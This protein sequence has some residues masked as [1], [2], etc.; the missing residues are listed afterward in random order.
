MHGLHNLRMYVFMNMHEMLHMQNV[1]QL[2]ENLW[3]LVLQQKQCANWGS[4]W[5]WFSKLIVK[6]VFKAHRHDHVQPLLQALHWL[7]VN[8]KIHY[9]LSTICH[10][11]SWLIPC[12]SP[13]TFSLCVHLPHSLV[14]P[15]THGHFAS[16]MLKLNLWPT[17]LLCSEAVEFSPFPHLSHSVLPCFKPALKTPLQS[18]PQPTFQTLS[19]SFCPPPHPTPP[20][21]LLLSSMLH[22]SCALQH[23]YAC[24]CVRMCGVQRIWCILF[25]QFT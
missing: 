16:S 13:L 18:I 10:N 1:T 22:F 24:M 4:W 5:N 9:T 12:I 15:Q 7:P 8:A 23:V 2:W 3:V 11:F 20:P 19:S 25:L 21:S 17:L 14:L 6:Q